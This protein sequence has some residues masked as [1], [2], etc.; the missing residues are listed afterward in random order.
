MSEKIS[1]SLALAAHN[2]SPYE[3]TVLLCS[4]VRRLRFC[5]GYGIR[6]AMPKTKVGLHTNLAPQHDR[7][8]FC[9]VACVSTIVC[10]CRCLVERVRKRAR[11]D[12][13]Q[14]M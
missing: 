13:Y 4:R 9:I 14:V 12:D 6:Q 5:A 11:S 2:F 8:R 3:S 7:C 1:V 10:R